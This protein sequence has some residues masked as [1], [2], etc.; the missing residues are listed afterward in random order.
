[1]ENE[2]FN[3]TKYGVYL[4]PETME[5]VEQLYKKDNAESKSIFIER[6]IEFYCG[7]LTAENYREYFPSVITSTFDAKLQRMEDRMATL[8]YK[9]AV[10]LAM[11]LH[12]IAATNDVDDMNLSQLRGV[13]NQ[14]VSRTH[15]KIKFE[16]AVRYQK[17]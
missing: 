4:T 3:K 15:G 10:E 7:Y 1:M 11:L 2:P 12:V 5:K 17:G 6:A 14:E 16:D 13:C 8:L 9:Q